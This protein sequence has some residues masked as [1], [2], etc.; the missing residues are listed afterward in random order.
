VITIVQDVENQKKLPLMLF[1]KVQQRYRHGL[2][3]SLSSRDF[4]S[5]PSIYAHMDYLFWR[6]NS[7]VETE[8]DRDPYPWIIWY[9]WKAQNDKLFRGID[10]DPLEL[11]RYAE[12][13]CQGW[14]N[15]NDTI[16]SSPHEHTIEKP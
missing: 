5:L 10:R 12:G 4:S 6:K 16:S 9:I 14:F 7:I 15:A 3:E 13:E 2:S 11:V 1:L 8:L